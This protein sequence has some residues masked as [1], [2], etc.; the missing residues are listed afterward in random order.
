MPASGAPSRSRRD[1]LGGR[2]AYAA[3]A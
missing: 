3:Y 1:P 2:P